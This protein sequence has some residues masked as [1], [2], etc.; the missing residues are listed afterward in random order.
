MALQSRSRARERL[1]K[2][3]VFF[4]DFKH[5]SPASRTVRPPN[6]R[7]HALPKNGSVHAFGELF[8]RGSSSAVAV[9]LNFEGPQQHEQ[10]SQRRCVTAALLWCLTHSC[11]SRACRRLDRV[12]RRSAVEAETQTRCSVLDCLSG[13]HILTLHPDQDKG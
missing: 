2:K 1:F 4:G 12:R 13:S 8:L 6:R 3:F 10:L 5:L 7:A 9:E 11:T